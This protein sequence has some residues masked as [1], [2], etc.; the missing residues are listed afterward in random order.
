M[1]TSSHPSS[2]LPPDERLVVPDQ[3]YELVAGQVVA[4]SPAKEPHARRHAK[5]AA[6]LEAYAAEGYAVAA[7]MLTRAS[8]NED[9]APDA[10]VYP[11]A[12][13]P[14]TGGRGLEELAFEVVSAESLAH[15]GL[16]AASLTRRGVRRVFAIDVQRERGLEWSRITNAWEILA[17]DAVIDDRALV[18]PLPV[19]ELVSAGRGSVAMARA[20]VAS[21]NEVIVAVRDEG[22]VDG[23]AEAIIA[24]LEG[25][26]LTPTDEQHARLSE[27][28]DIA[29]LRRLLGRAG[30]CQSIAELL[31]GV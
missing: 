29:D 19:T 9:F 14:K 15:A 30:T 1:V 23:L 27:I 18:L 22:R 12:R 2:Q 3:G 4:V 26:G 31:R 5:L 28:R 8:P 24:V 11:A 6:L 7:D 21:N 13:D 25:R 10:S 16:K 17:D 20:L